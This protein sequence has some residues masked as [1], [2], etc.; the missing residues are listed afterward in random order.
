[1]N[2]KKEQEQFYTFRISS[3]RKQQIKRLAADLI[4][5]EKDIVEMILA[6]YFDNVDD[7]K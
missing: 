5:K 1:M 2:D 6:D 3:K 4:K 7:G